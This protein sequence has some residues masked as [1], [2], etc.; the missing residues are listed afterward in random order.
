[1]KKSYTKGAYTF[2]EVSI[3]SDLGLLESLLVR[4]TIKDKIYFESCSYDDEQRPYASRSFS[5]V[6]GNFNYK[7]AFLENDKKS[8]VIEGNLESAEV[9]YCLMN[10]CLSKLRICLYLLQNLLSWKR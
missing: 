6:D 1:M 7:F 10:T 4:R 2:D 5:E 8:A 9:K 3:I